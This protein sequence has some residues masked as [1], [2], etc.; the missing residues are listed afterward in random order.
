MLA[1]F[2]P[3]R[4]GIL[5]NQFAARGWLQSLA[6]PE[7]NH[8]GGEVTSGFD[9][10]IVK[11][12]GSPGAAEIYYTTDGTDPRL[13]GGAANPTAIHSAGPVSINIDTAKQIK[14]HIKNGT[15]WS[16]LIDAI[17]TL[18][19]LHPLRITELHY[20]PADH[21]GV[22][23]PDD[24]EFIE[25][26]N[27]GTS[28]V[29][30][31]GVEIAQF[32]AQPYSFGSGINLAAGQ[33]I[34]VARNPA[35][36][37]SV[38]GTN[39]NL[40]PIGYAGAN[41]SNGGERIK[42]VGPFG[43]T[44]QNFTYLDTPPWPTSPDGGGTSLEIIDPLGDPTESDQLARSAVP[45]GS[46]GT[47][48]AAP[49]DYDGNG[50]VEQNDY[51]LW[52]STFGST[53]IAGTGADGNGNGTIDAADYVIWRKNLP[54][55]GGTS[56]TFCDDSRDKIGAAVATEDP[57]AISELPLET[58]NLPQQ[59]SLAA[60]SF[61]SNFDPMNRGRR[62]LNRGVVIREPSDRNELLAFI[63]IA[64]PVVIAMEELT[65]DEAWFGTRR[66]SAR[67]PGSS[68]DLDG[69]AVDSALTV[70]MGFGFLIRRNSI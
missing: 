44:L 13:A 67:S 31:A 39:I 51:D 8:Y 54:P 10:T 17:Y 57:A 20:H 48:G 1:N 35:V 22:T 37:Q 34:V 19:E 7:F 23:D 64:N 63:S 36:F 61:Q 14:A 9:V 11:P 30:L 29:S 69:A 45:G 33:R 4:T 41:L 2:F 27:T 68:S 38:Y 42:L 50:T 15:E 18:P 49:G 52:R 53:I 62:S 43:E 25:V 3:Q 65:T 59:T 28:P 58:A 70:L 56:L 66:K 6:A 26:M 12:A 46:P 32:A 5:L 24:L 60:M 55:A 21:P 16:A 40:A 47:S